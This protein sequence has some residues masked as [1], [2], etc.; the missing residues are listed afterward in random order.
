MF[1]NNRYVGPVYQNIEG[2]IEEQSENTDNAS[3]SQAT[4]GGDKLNDREIALPLIADVGVQT[5][6]SLAEVENAIAN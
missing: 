5:R 6:H 1:K 4:S 3:Q 2:T